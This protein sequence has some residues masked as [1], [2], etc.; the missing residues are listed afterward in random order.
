MG[1]IILPVLAATLAS[2]AG[3]EGDVRAVCACSTLSL[4][5]FASGPL[6]LPAWATPMVQAKGPPLTLGRCLSAAAPTATSALALRAY[7]RTAP[8]TTPPDLSPD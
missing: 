4:R 7:R 1:R 2:S 5:S 8:P 6:L 3:L